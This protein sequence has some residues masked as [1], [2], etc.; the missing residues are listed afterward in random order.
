M[1]L[2]WK[3]NWQNTME[4]FE[5][6]WRHEGL[7]LATWGRPD[8]TGQPIEE[9]IDP[10]PPTSPEHYYTDPVFRARC[11]HF[12]LARGAYP[13]D[14]L[15]MADT[16]IGPGTLALFLGSSPGF[17]PHTVWYEPCIDPDNPEDTPPFV[18]DPDNRWWQIVE[19]TL[20]ESM[21][22]SQGRYLV[23]CPDLI[24]NIDILAAMRDPQ[25][26]LYDLIERP[27]W[28]L[29]KVHEINAVWFEAYQRIYDI[30][31]L[32]DGSSAFDAFRLWGPGKTAKVQCDA[33]AMISPNMFAEFVVPALTEQCQWLDHSMFHL[34]GHQCIP[35]LDHLLAISA[36]DAIEWTPDPQVPPG[37]DPHWFGMYRR[38]LASGKSLQAIGI[39]PEQVEPMLDA[40]GPEGL[41][42]HVDCVDLHQL[43][44][45]AR[46]ADRYRSPLVHS[47]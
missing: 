31:K 7:V 36:L 14:T 47:T 44:E 11:N 17:G 30:I 4:H 16:H 25:R 23:G 9:T 2:A 12:A 33:A 42:M 15:P 24:E 22:L 6:W 26:F 35:H 46:T 43:E 1:T 5:A 18:F 27:A 41:Y 45:L 28:V 34:D 19:Q 37:G 3:S 40:L 20:R 38:I 39:Q 10:G 21:A 13:A 32:P 29:G 8:R